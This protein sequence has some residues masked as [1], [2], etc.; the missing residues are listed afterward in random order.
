MGYYERREEIIRLLETGEK[1]TL[2]Q[3]SDRFGVSRK[4]ALNDITHLTKNHRIAVQYG[5]SGGYFLTEGRTVTLTDRQVAVIYPVLEAN[6]LRLGLQSEEIL[7]KLS[8]ALTP[9][10]PK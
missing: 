4:T 9:K 10:H 6:R 1:L 3:I 8:R 7:S 2:R 5:R